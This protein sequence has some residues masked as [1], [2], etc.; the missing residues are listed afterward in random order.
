MERFFRDLTINSLRRAVF[1]SVEE[2]TK[3]FEEHIRIHNANPKPFI[4]SAAAPDIL[5]KVKRGRKSLHKTH[6]A[7]RPTLVLC[8]P[9]SDGKKSEELAGTN[10]IPV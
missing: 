8:H 4:W 6:Y 5:E 1:H 3:A 7:R 9:Y 10:I 2:L